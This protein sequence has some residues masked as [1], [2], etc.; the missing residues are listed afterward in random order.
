M[1]EVVTRFKQPRV[2]SRRHLDRIATLP[3]SVPG[4]PTWRRETVVPHHLTC[5]PEPKGRGIKASDIFACPLC[6]HHH[7]GSDEAVHARG[8]ELAWWGELGLDP[9]AIAS[10]HAFLSR[11][12]GLL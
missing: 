1:S 12:L 8:D 5:G 11:K 9:I 2:R 3:C 10:W 7:L 4:C 6:F